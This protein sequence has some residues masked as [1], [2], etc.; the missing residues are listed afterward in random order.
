MSRLHH[1][2][3]GL[4]YPAV[5]GTVIVNVLPSV[6]QL[7]AGQPGSDLQL[8]IKL[9][10]TLGIAFHFAVDYVFAGE[11]P[12]HGWLGL[13][14]D[15]GILLSLW[16]AATSVH[17]NSAEAAD[18]R[19]LCIALIFVYVLF[20]AYLYISRK[21]V[22]SKHLLFAEFFG[23]LWFIVGAAWFPNWGFAFTGLLVCGAL[24]CDRSGR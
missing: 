1:L 13:V 22:Q 16:A 20:L 9:L 21:Q 8:L 17:S 3:Y 14:L 24:L 5:L 12:E 6:F 10:L 19:T 18:I 23:L 11:A 7:A 15:S 2:M 4:L